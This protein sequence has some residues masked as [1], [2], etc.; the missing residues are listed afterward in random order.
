MARMHSQRKGRSHSKRPIRL[1]NPDWCQRTPEE[2]EELIVKLAK[3]G[4][5]PSMIGLILRDQ[6]GVPLTKAITGKTITQILNENEQSLKVPEDL[7]HLISRAVT[8]RRHIEG[9]GKD[10]HSGY[11]LRL[12]ESKIRR[13]VKYYRRRGILPED[14]KYTP[15]QAALLIR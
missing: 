4:H 12:I 13:L 15:E 2:V 3:E 14:W 6:H 8:L 7:F 1:E 5:Q 11:G 10:L 9:S